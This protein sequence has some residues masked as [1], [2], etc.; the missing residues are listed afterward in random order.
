[1][2]GGDPVLDEQ[3]R[4][5]GGRV[6]AL[7]ADAFESP[8][9]RDQEVTRSATGSGGQGERR[10]RRRRRQTD[11]KEEEEAELVA[12]L[13]RRPPRSRALPTSNP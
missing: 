3:S 5:Y 13:R 9:G 11:N 6:W 8:I 10:R 12:P 7:V 2:D 4:D 1:M